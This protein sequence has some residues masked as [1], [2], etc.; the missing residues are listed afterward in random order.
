MNKKLSVR[1][2]ILQ[3]ASSIITAL[4]RNELYD[5][6]VPIASSNSNANGFSKKSLRYGE[7]SVRFAQ[8]VAVAGLVSELENGWLLIYRLN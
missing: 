1:E 7:T 4:S 2:A 3:F 6:M 8:L 5:I